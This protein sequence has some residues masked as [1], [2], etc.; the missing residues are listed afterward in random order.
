[1]ARAER[2]VV[3]PLSYLELPWS[4]GLSALTVWQGIAPSWKRFLLERYVHSLQRWCS[5]LY[6]ASR[7]V[8]AAK[9]QPSRQEIQYVGWRVISK[10]IAQIW[11]HVNKERTRIYFSPCSKKEQ[12]QDE[13]IERT[14]EHGWRINSNELISS[15]TSTARR[16]GRETMAWS[17][18]C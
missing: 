5:K 1:M 2:E 8:E 14:S 4:H 17:T 15:F 3:L 10:R 11:L 13:S 18:D 7:T 16:I 12:T 6:P 9:K